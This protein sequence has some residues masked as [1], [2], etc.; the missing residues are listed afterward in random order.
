[1]GYT[2]TRS[3]CHTQSVGTAGSHIQWGDVAAWVGGIATAVALFLTY[4]LLRITRREQRELQAEKRQA[5]ARL[6]SAWTGQLQQVPGDPARS[7]AV[8]LQNSSH[9]PVYGLRA[10][11]GFSWSAKG[12]K[13]AEARIVYLMPPEHRHQ[14]KVELDSTRRGTDVSGPPLP[15]ELLF[16]DATGK[17]WHRNR[18]GRLA[19]ITDE[20]P[21]AG[22]KYFFRPVAGND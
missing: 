14:E 4:G 20:L 5:Q 9:E 2:H 19:E 8:T 17:R 21:L 3:V 16:S 7:V 18:Y 13:F 6:I 22:D 11:V 15:V 12:S 10:A 1:V